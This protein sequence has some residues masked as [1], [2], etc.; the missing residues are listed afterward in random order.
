M[1]K[2]VG[3]TTATP[4][5][6]PD[7][8]QTNPRMSDYIKNKPDFDG[9]SQKVDT[10][11]EKVGEISVANQINIAIESAKEDCY[12]NDAV[13]LVEAQKASAAVQIA[14]DNHSGNANIH[15][16]TD[17]KAKWNS[18]LD[19]AKAYADTAAT[20]AANTVKNDLL[21]GAG[22]AYDT[23]KELGDLINENTDAVEALELVSAGRKT[24][25]G[26]EIF[27]DYTNNIASA[28]YSHAEG[29]C[30][31]A[32]ALY[33]HAE[34][35]RTTASGRSSHAEGEYSTASGNVSHAEGDSTKSTGF[36]SHAEGRETEASK[37]GAH[38]EG[39][40]T[41][42]TGYSAHAEGQ[43]STAT[44]SSSHAEGY[45]T[46]ANKLAS[47]A[48]GYET[49][50]SSDNTHSEGYLTKA[51][52]KGFKITA[53][54]DSGNGVGVYTLKT[55]TGLEAGMEYSVRISEAR[56]KA[57]KITAISGNK[58][59]V[60][61]FPKVALETDADSA[62]TYS[63]E[64]YLTIVGR[65]DL[66]DTDIGFHAHAEGENTIAQD[67]S[68]HAE[69]KDTMAIGQF[70]HAEGRQTVAGYAAHAEGRQT[71]A[72]GT[73]SHS[74]GF[75]TKAMGNNSHAEGR[76]TEADGLGAHAE[77][78]GDSDTSR[79]TA[80]GDGSHAEGHNAVAYSKYSHVEG[81]S[82]KAGEFAEG[83][84]EQNYRAAHAEGVRTVAIR[85]GSHAEGV[86]SRA[87][88]QAS[89]A[90]GQKSY[91]IGKYSHA[92]GYNTIASGEAQHVA[93]KYNVE[94]TANEYAHILGGGTSATNRKNLHTIDWDGNARFEGSITTGGGAMH[95]N[96]YY[97]NGN[98]AWIEISAVGDSSDLY[99]N[100]EG[101]QCNLLRIYDVDASGPIVVSGVDTPVRN[102]H[103]ANKKYVDESVSQKSQVQIITWEADD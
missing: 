57:G 88:G 59:T 52:G 17:D 2:I 82:T 67:R 49:T 87:E 72:I 39:Y 69:G 58:V 62:Y 21:N 40:K 33:A 24:E 94:D 8:E 81:D 34:G 102:H 11:D 53:V 65:P 30:T 100:D 6:I 79:T 32:S 50:A 23:L 55:V 28:E 25:E 41:K 22:D 1:S 93:G 64:N 10:I 15:V 91:A 76:Y 85:V 7:W 5:A 96:K 4:V 19:S 84:S 89:H 46:T 70:G 44:A 98:Y 35:S 83:E 56:Y 75:K 9:L 36:A 26:G 63:I 90:E 92:E 77:G 45:Y 101:V 42:A 71:E 103:A 95:I 97:D 86:D 60:N 12:N 37:E 99:E 13:V 51:G 47:H 14:L 43:G 61:G 20:N 31:T 48:E 54:S 16:T 29:K 3:N 68:A 38:A 27:N 74:E 18:T 80:I 73:M 78:V 66:G